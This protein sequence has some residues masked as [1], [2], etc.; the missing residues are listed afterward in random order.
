VGGG[1]SAGVTQVESANQNIIH[2]DGNGIV[3]ILATTKKDGTVEIK[4]PAAKTN[5]IIKK[6]KNET[7]VFDFSSYAD[8]PGVNIPNSSFKA[9][10]K[11]GLAVEIIFPQ[12]TVTFD[13][14]AVASVSKLV[15]SRQIRVEINEAGEAVI[16]SGRRIIDK[17]NGTVTVSA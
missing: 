9:F 15:W 17:Y 4:L 10:S 2:A 14:E 1:E 16:K 5:E 13:S 3:A 6:A 8:V 12:G 7:V 11:T